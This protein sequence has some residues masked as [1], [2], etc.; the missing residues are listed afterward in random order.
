MKSAKISVLGLLCCAG[1]AQAQLQGVSSSQDAYIV[2]MQSGVWTKSILTVGDSVNLK[3]D[4]T[5]Y[6]MVGIPDGLGVIDNGDGTFDV[7]MNH[8]LGSTAGITRAH[9]S[10][11][12]F[13]S[14][15]N[16]SKSNLQVNSGKDQIN[17]VKLWNGTGYTDGTTAFGRFCSGDLAK[18]S[19]YK[20]VD[21]DGTVY[22]TDAKIYMAGEEIGSE[23]RLF[24]HIASGANNGTSYELAQ[25]GKFS[26]E[27]AVANTKAQK[28]TIVIGTDDSTPG[29]VYMYVGN[30]TTTGNDV[31]RAGLTNG[32]LYGIKAN[33]GPSES[34]SGTP[35]SGTF[36]LASLNALQSGS[37]LQTQSTS[38]GVTEFLRPEDGAWDTRAGFENNFYFV[39]T[40]R[41]NS[42]SQVG[43]SKL[44]RMTYNDI[45]NPE[46]GGTL[47][48]LMDG[49]QGQQ[50]FDNLCIDKFGRILIQEDVG[51][52]SLLGK[53]WMYDI[54][55]GQY[56]AIAQH[57]PSRFVSGGSRFITQDE[58]SSGIID[59]SDILGDGYYLLDVQAHNSLGGEL[60]E[61]GQLL[62]MYVD[63][64]IVPTPGA[65]GVLAVGA[66]AASRRRRA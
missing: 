2:G 17:N 56:G 66:L 21:T 65:L 38:F 23:G 14:R 20:F 12:A 49:T 61:G 35:T 26:W 54:A 22:G 25:H 46:L 8:E 5:P 40:D 37:G 60:V 6:R 15:W 4:G 9:G 18:Q 62:V 11:G 29:Q 27:N 43:R 31:E 47:T 34:R 45:A 48:V 28:K 51:N 50:M 1:L 63:P 64:S 10:A 58:E 57:D 3:P 52:N 39:T 7:L 44:W 53:I 19:A 36:T 32:Q 59:A 55:T 24:A 42:G 16:I 30:K 13:V 41:V 33:W